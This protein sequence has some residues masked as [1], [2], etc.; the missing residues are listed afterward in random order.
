MVDLSALRQR[1]ADLE[2][3]LAQTEQALKSA[4]RAD[5]SRRKIVLGGAVLAALRNGEIDGSVLR[6][7]LGRHVTDRDK[8]LFSGSALSIGET[9]Q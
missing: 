7:I 4:R 6:G 1:K 8:R 3:R 5:D 2:S 9:A